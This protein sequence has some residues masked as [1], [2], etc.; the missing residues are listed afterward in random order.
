[1]KRRTSNPV[2]LGQ[3]LSVW[4]LVWT[5]GAQAQQPSP[6]APPGSS[7]AASI[8]SPAGGGSVSARTGPRLS[9]WA[10]EILKLT[11]AGVSQGVV[12]AFIDNAGFFALGADQIIYLADLGVPDGLI[13]RMLQH[14]C[15]LMLG[16]SPPSIVS[17]PPYE[18]I[19]FTMP[20]PPQATAGLAGVSALQTN[21]AARTES[22]AEPSP[23]AMA[24]APGAASFAVTDIPTSTK[25]AMSPEAGASAGAA[26]TP[27]RTARKTDA[28]YPV[29]EPQPVEL[30]PPILFLN[31]SEPQPNLLVIVGFPKS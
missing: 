15:D 22:K 25:P 21:Q 11:Q 13:Q 26:E 19:R 16:V 31:A 17:D 2:V 30:L 8:V 24:P 7:H 10:K 3:W 29:R 27:P 14:D 28:R 12:E 9:P 20:E 5:L 4:G 6:E 23:A 18:P 1:M